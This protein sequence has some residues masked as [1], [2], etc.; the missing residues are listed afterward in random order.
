MKIL[1]E[2][3]V[4]ALNDAV[5][6]CLDAAQLY[7]A[8]A[9]QAEDSAF[10][11]ELEA[12]ARRRRE[13]AES[14]SA[15]VRRLGELPSAPPQ[16]ELQLLEQ[17]AQQLRASLAEASDRQLR[18]DCR[19]KEAAIAEAARTVQEHDL[20]EEALQAAA[21]LVADAQESLAS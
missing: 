12:L 11:A 2:E 5:A 19:D 14:L 20:S 17:A 8:A 13:A 4:V 15:E 3:R 9:A 18:D 10:A 7:E 6:L 21:D 1:K 16:E